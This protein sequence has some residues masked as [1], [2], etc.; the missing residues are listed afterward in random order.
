M[1][2]YACWLL[3]ISV[4]LLDGCKKKRLPADAA[5]SGS[6][7][8]PPAAGGSAPSAPVVQPGIPI[9][10]EKPWGD[11]SKQEK[12][13]TYIFWLS[14]L[15]GADPGK[16]AQITSKIQ[17]AGLSPADRAELEKLRELYGV[18]RINF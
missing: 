6:V 7:D 8:A 16:Q 15:K 3:V 4:V 13:E 18:P 14:Q 5:S 1:I 2:R 12:H 10:K 11:R 9:P 17:A